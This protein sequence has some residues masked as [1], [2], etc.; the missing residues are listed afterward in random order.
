MWYEYRCNNC[1]DLW[2]SQLFAKIGEYVAWCDCGGRYQ[3]IVSVPQ[4]RPSAEPY[5]NYAVGDYVKDDADFKR[6]LHAKAI[7]NSNLTGV[8]HSYE[9]VYPSDLKNERS[10]GVDGGESIEHSRR[11]NPRA[12]KPS[13]TKVIA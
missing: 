11:H 10:V 3:R 7:D 4:T 1:G 2:E 8:D 6:K 13:T 12:Y 5:F 9:P